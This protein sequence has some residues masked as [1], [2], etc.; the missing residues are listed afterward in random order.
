M[1][2]L[3]LTTLTAIMLSLVGCATT[4]P[5]NIPIKKSEHCEATDKYADVSTKQLQLS[6]QSDA[7]TRGTTTKY[8]VDSCRLLASQTKALSF[9]NIELIKDEIIIGEIGL[10]VFLIQ[11]KQGNW[12]V[13]NFNLLYTEVYIDTNKNN[14]NDNENSRIR[15]INK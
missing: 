10:V 5:K 7:E 11:N 1:V 3:A 12:E 8:N 4:Q 15:M 14:N 2:R 13:V 9:I 6:L